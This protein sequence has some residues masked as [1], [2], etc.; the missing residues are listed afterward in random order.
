MNVISQW[1][2]KVQM[3]CQ[4]AEIEHIDVIIDQC[5]VDFS[6]LP[7]LASFRVPIEWQSLYQGLPEDIYPEDAPVLVRVNLSDIEHVQWLQNLATE[8]LASAPLLVCGS[9]WLF[10]QLSVWLRDC[11]NAKHE[12]REGIFRFWDTRIFPYLF[13]HILDDEQQEQLQK[14]VLFWSWLD[15]DHQ[16]T[17]RLGSGE[18]PGSDESVAQIEFTDS[19]FEKLMC[20]SDVRQ[21]L[22]Y[23]KIPD[24]L[25]TTRQAEFT[26][27]Y[28]AMLVATE[29]QVIFDDKRSAWVMDYL[30]AHHSA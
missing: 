20:V 8:M 23:E 9:S 22:G 6:V 10:E 21:F 17:L 5:A 25:F 1:M 15:C 16:P 3:T 11:A 7:A 28:E 26:A 14:P 24:G 18:A 19:Q 29:K 2:D 30:V 27:C 4:R 12:G 13:S